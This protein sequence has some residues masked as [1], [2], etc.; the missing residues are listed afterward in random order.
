[1]VEKW[2]NMALGPDGVP[3][4][5]TK[6]KR[7]RKWTFPQMPSKG[8]FTLRSSRRPRPTLQLPMRCV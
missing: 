1:M 8:L 7:G 3:L 6:P 2:T 4:K 5:V